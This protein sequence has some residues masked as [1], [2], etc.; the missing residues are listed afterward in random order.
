[1]ICPYCKS[2]MQKGYVH[3]NKHALRWYPNVPQGKSI[4][5][6]YNES[7]KLSSVWNGGNVIVHRCEKC[8]KLIIDEN[9]LEV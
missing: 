3:S 7:K 5:A 8:K 4:F 2:E 1:M 6:S 9:E